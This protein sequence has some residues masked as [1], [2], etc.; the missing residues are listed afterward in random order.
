M[1]LIDADKLLKE[2]D[3]FVPAVAQEVVRTLVEDS[4][5]VEPK[6]EGVV[7]ANIDVD[8][9]TIING[10][11]DRLDVV[12]C[13]DCK[14]YLNVNEEGQIECCTRYLVNKFNPNDYCSYGER[15]EP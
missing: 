3:V 10:L 5:E 15:K 1:K 2:V 7:L 11:L 9:E 4:P 6:V 13:K 14:R 12:R 8:K